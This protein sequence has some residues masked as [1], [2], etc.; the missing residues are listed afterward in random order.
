[1]K[2]LIVSATS[3]E[4]AAF[5]A[6]LGEPTMINYKLNRYKKNNTQFDVLVTGVGMIFTTFHLSS[7]LAHEKYDW[8]INA[9]VAGA[10]DDKLNLGELVNINQ[11][12]FY[13][14]GAEDAENWL[15]IEDLRLL[16]TNDWPYTSAGIEN[17]LQIDLPAIKQLKKVKGQTVNKIHGNAESIK[18]MQKRSSAQ[19]ESMEGAAFLYCCIQHQLPCIQIRTISNYVEVRNKTNWKMQE[20]IANLNHFLIENFIL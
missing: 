17:I 14:L 20:A 11:D 1:M 16:S 10:I 2:I 7:L 8:A 12:Y 6:S 3:F 9:G 4:I 19:V 15:S 13:E 5:T 18:I